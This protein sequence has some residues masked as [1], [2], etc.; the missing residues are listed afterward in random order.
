MS[1][2]EIL[3]PLVSIIVPVYN[4]E[5]CLRNCI[6]SIINQTYK[7]LEIILID[8]GSTDRSAAICMA[9]EKDDNRIKALRKNNTGVSDTRNCGIKLATGKYICFIDSDDTIDKK[10]IEELVEPTKRNDYD[11][12]LCN[13]NEIYKDRT[14]KREVNCLTEGVFHDEYSGLV[15]VTRVPFV[16]LYKSEII[17]KY[18]LTFQVHISSFEDEIFNLQYYEYVNRYFYVDKALYN[19]HRIYTTSRKIT[20]KGFYGSVERLKFAKEFYD[21]YKIKNGGTILNQQVLYTLKKYA[22]LID[23]DNDYKSFKNRINGLI[24]IIDSK[25]LPKKVSD[26]IKLI[27]LKN[28]IIFPLYIYFRIKKN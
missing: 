15:K 4:A 23:D 10:Y 3:N 24:N 20:K 26:K 18:G 19:Y 2:Y 7:N 17:K 6:D 1:E 14:Q 13:I 16:K 9:Y 28:N 5:K 22:M 25:S 21:K 12:V 11:L 8:D 27:L